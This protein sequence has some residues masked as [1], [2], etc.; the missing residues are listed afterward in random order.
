MT[1][2]TH[3]RP[4]AAAGLTS[5]RYKGR[6][7]WIMI[8]AK[9][10]RDALREACRSTHDHKASMDRLEVWDLLAGVYKQVQP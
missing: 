1:R 4:C 5:Y 10:H 6:Y 9:D 2:P 3:D 7:G 8:G